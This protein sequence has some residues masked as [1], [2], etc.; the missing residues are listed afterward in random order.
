MNMPSNPPKET[1]PEWMSLRVTGVVPVT[2]YRLKQIA[3]DQ[4]SATLRVEHKTLR[5]RILLLIDLSGH[6]ALLS[7]CEEI[8]ATGWA[9]IPGALIEG[10]IILALGIRPY[11]VGELAAANAN[12]D[13]LV[14]LMDC[15]RT[16]EDAESPRL[17]AAFAHIE[18]MPANLRDV[19]SEVVKAWLRYIGLEYGWQSQGDVSA[20]EPLV[21]N[22]AQ[23]LD[24][25]L[26]D[27]I[28]VGLRFPPGFDSDQLPAT[29]ELNE[30]ESACFLGILRVV[31]DF[32][33]RGQ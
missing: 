17:V 7:L 22:M 12:I 20:D 5:N 4:W 27:G 31:L 19:Q 13:A 6:D 14:T 26:A 24:D 18:S 2:Q 28:S 32:R 21:A 25:P 9:A 30:L 8:V 3:G 23:E 16:G 15:L 10:G 11:G 33:N 1:L 29:V